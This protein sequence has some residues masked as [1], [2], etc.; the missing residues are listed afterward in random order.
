MSA[1]DD[2]HRCPVCAR[3]VES[4]TTVMELTAEQALGRDRPPTAIPDGAGYAFSLEPCGHPATLL[5]LREA[6]I[7][8]ERF[9]H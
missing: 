2:V 6:G 7:E 5:Q 8:A 3:P 4:V 1:R 9:E